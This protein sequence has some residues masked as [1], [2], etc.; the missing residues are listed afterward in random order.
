MES[1]ENNLPGKTIQDFLLDDAAQGKIHQKYAKSFSH[2]LSYALRTETK[3]SIRSNDVL[4]LEVLKNQLPEFSSWTLFQIKPTALHGFL[5]MEPEYVFTLIDIF[6]GG[7]AASAVP[8]K[9]RRFSEIEQRLIKRVAVSMLEDLQRAWE[10]TFPTEMVYGSHKSEPIDIT[11]Y[12][13]DEDTFRIINFEFLYQGTRKMTADL[14]YPLQP[15]N[16]GKFLTHEHPQTVALILSHLSGSEEAVSALQGFTSDL[17]ADVVHRIATM[18][19]IPP[20]VTT[21]ITDVASKALFQKRE[22]PSGPHPGSF[23]KAVELLNLFDKSVQ[24]GIFQEWSK[25]KNVDSEFI[26]KMKQRL[27]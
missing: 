4:S 26:E 11:D 7:S 27:S 21:E 19:G 20:G 23:E 16:L 12:F 25:M 17:R 14:C 22:I 5:I 8:G 13:V 15:K 24:N 9:Q 2:T 10:P 6:Y 1:S 3:M 18:T